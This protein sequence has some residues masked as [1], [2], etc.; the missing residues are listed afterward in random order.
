MKRLTRLCNRYGSDKGTTEDN[1]HGFSE[2]YEQFFEGLESPKILELG[3]KSGAFEKAISKFY[4]GDCL[5]YCVDIV[6]C[7]ECF[8]DMG[9][10]RFFQCDCGNEDAIKNLIESFGDI[11]FDVVID[12]AS[13]YWPHQFLSLL[14]FRRKV[15]DNGY[16]ILE[17]L[18]SSYDDTYRANIEV[19]VS[20][21][22]YVVELLPVNF[23]T[24][25]ENQEIISSV[26]EVFLYSKYNPK[27][28]YGEN[29]YWHSI[30]A[31]L[32]I[33]RHGT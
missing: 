17:D 7:S 3:V 28:L 8:N 30:T 15:K 14:H 31:V 33:N 10:V 6:D 16:F 5:I 24:E 26:K 18:H 1:S 25:E 32:K 19:R 4:D 9:N 22:I 21:L 20:P 11:E 12:D 27:G 29:N 23:Y 2:F 13:H